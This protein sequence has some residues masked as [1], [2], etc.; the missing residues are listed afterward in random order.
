MAAM[1]S[2]EKRPGSITG[3]SGKPWTRRALTKAWIAERRDNAALKPLKAAGLVLH[4]LRRDGRCDGCRGLA[5]TPARS[6][7]S[8]ACRRRWLRAIAGTRRSRRS[9]SAAI[10]HL[11]ER[12]ENDAGSKPNRG[13]GASR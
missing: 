10:L 6:R 2:W 11:E 3:P 13:G 9:V 7:I 8:S 4:G 12:R 5:P 1:A